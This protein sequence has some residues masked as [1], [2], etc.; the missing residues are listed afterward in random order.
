MRQEFGSLDPDA[1]DRAFRMRL[2]DMQL[3]I[4]PAFA[5]STAV[6]GKLAY[7]LRVGENGKAKYAHITESSLGDRDAERCVIDLFMKATWPAAVDGDGVVSHNATFEPSDWTRPE[8]WSPAKVQP[9]LRSAKR[10]AKCAQSGNGSWQ[11][12]AYIAKDQA[13]GSGKLLAAGGAHSERDGGETLDCLLGELGDVK[14][15]MPSSEVAK[16]TFSYP[17]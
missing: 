7:T 2:P 6:S 8:A 10:F 14:F 15:P 13:A 5:K 17:F 4:E 3:C 11:I 12:T 1:M 9:V 16:V